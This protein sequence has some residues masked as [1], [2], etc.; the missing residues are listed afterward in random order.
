[1][2]SLFARL[3][4][5]LADRSA[6]LSARKL[7]RAC[8]R[9]TRA[10]GLPVE[11]KVRRILGL[12]DEA[13]FAGALGASLGRY[14]FVVA[15]R[16][17][18]SSSSSTERSSRDGA[19]AGGDA[20]VHARTTLDLQRGRVDMVFLDADHCSVTGGRVSSRCFVDVVLHELV[21]V[22][23]FLV[24][25]DLGMMA[26]YDPVDEDNVLFRGWQKKLFD[27]RLV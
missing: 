26:G 12:V 17:S 21:H 27:L 10:R 9:A 13:F 24:R 4:A 3:D 22:I 1:M 7:K 2:A 15:D 19:D 14:R 5:V 25:T 20:G 6:Y 11:T 8:A 18:S 23:E 16:T